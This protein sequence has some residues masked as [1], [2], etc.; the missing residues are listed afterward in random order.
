MAISIPVP[1]GKIDGVSGTVPWSRQ[2][3]RLMHLFDRL[4]NTFHGRSGVTPR[5]YFISPW[6]GALV[7]QTTGHRLGTRAPSVGQPA[8]DNM[9][10]LHMLTQWLDGCQET[11]RWRNHMAEGCTMS[12]FNT[13]SVN[14]KCLL[15]SSV[16]V[17]Q[18]SHLDFQGKVIRGGTCQHAE[19]QGGWRMTIQHKVSSSLFCGQAIHQTWT[20]MWDWMHFLMYRLYKRPPLKV[21]WRMVL[22]RLSRRVTWPPSCQSPSL[23]TVVTSKIMAEGGN[24]LKL[25][26]LLTVVTIDLLLHVMIRS[27]RSFQLL[28][29][30]QTWPFLM[31]LLLLL[32]CTSLLLLLLLLL[33]SHTSMVNVW[34]I[35]RRVHTTTRNL[36]S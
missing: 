32:L 6:L 4:A 9:W 18:V 1:N 5:N 26:S 17:I 19:G 15:V 35:W 14:N 28:G 16:Y 25:I 13:I 36:Y 23:M 27:D 11:D 2:C 22:E 8:S 34:P 3:Q 30:K 33:F 24:Y 10:P 31:L 29:L 12:K 21:P 20:S 7:F